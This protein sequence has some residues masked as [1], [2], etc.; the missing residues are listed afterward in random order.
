M[1]WSVAGEERF[2]GGW[3]STC[4]EMCAGL[5]CTVPLSTPHLIAKCRD[6]ENHLEIISAERE[7]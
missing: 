5:K 6:F 1:F 4:S 7:R 3:L 2:V